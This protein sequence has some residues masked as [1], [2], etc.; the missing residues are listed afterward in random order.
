MIFWKA[1]AAVLLIC[2][3]GLFIPQSGVSTAAVIVPSPN[4]PQE[5]DLHLLFLPP[6][7]HRESIGAAVKYLPYGSFSY[8]L[9]QGDAPADMSTRQ[10]ERMIR[11]LLGIS[12]NLIYISSEAERDAAVRLLRRLAGTGNE[13]VFSYGEQPHLFWRVLL[14]QAASLSD[15]QVIV[16]LGSLYDAAQISEKSLGEAFVLLSQAQ[17]R[18]RTVPGVFNREGRLPYEGALMRMGISQITAGM[19]GE[20]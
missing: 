10:L 3:C 11:R 8:L 16:H 6:E 14:E 12:P 5:F 20:N 17:G 7:R 2:S 1:A 4:H 15:S 19:E 18:L 13:L 9:D